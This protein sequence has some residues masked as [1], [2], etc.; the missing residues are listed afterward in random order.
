[1]RAA[2][3]LI[4]LLVAGCAPAPV[5]TVGE[6]LVHC[7]AYKG[8]IVRVA[9]YL[10]D[11]GG[12]S[13]HIYP[14]L[15]RAQSF[16]AEW[17]ELMRI[18]KIR[19]AEGSPDH[20]AQERVWARLDKIWPMGVGFNPAVEPRLTAH[21]NRYVIITG[22]M[23]EDTC[24]GRGGTDRSPGIHPTDVRVWKRSEGAPADVD[25]NAPFRPSTTL[26]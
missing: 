8:K 18:G 21:G 2:A 5:V 6:V 3:A 15:T 23:D 22:R 11:C 17:Q 12:Y 16:D 9:G 14:N 4:P 13:C 1:M 26:H 24:D 20:T 25:E 7:D 10:D 19:T